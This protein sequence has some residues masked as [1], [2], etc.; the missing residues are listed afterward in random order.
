[1]QVTIEQLR[2]FIKESL[3]EAKN[4][5]PACPLETHDKLKNAN[6]KKRAISDPKIAYGS[7]D[8][9]KNLCGTCAAFDVSPRMQ[10]CMESG[11]VDPTGLGYCWMHRFMCSAKNTCKTYV[12]GGPMKDDKDSLKKQKS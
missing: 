9:K 6:N 7:Y 2:L 10:D 11:N 8:S 3:E 12:G 5:S 1:M 4:E